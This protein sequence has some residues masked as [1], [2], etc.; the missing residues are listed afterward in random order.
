VMY[1]FYTYHN[2]VND[3]MLTYQIT[4]RPKDDPDGFSNGS[5]VCFSH[6]TYTRTFFLWLAIVTIGFVKDAKYHVC[7][8]QYICYLF[9]SRIWNAAGSDGRRVIGSASSM[10]RTATSSFKTP[11]A[12]SKTDREFNYLDN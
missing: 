8:F 1:L 3:V 6:L 12:A 4:Y 2:I 9:L 10:K 11:A 7:F 5:N